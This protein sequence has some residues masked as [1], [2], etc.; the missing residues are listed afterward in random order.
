MVI[1]VA[2]VAAAI[3]AAVTPVAAASVA[4]VEAVAAAAQ[5]VADVDA[6]V[7]GSCPHCSQAVFEIVIPFRFYG[8]ESK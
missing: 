1:P 6:P 8:N 7:A 4:E 5:A 3:Q 2:D